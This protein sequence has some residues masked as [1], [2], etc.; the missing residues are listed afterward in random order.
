VAV[1]SGCEGGADGGVGAGGNSGGEGGGGHKDK[2]AEVVS[3]QVIGILQ[4][5]WHHCWLIE[6]VWRELGGR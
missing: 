4:W 2:E 1:G 6:L 5:W 3:G